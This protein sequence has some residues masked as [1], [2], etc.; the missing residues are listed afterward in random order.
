[1]SE[2]VCNMCA[3]KYYVAHFKALDYGLILE[4]VHGVTEFN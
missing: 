3:K 2:L 4:N 1:M